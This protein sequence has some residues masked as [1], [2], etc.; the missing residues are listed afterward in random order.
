MP[1][2]PVYFDVSFDSKPFIKRVDQGTIRLL[3]FCK[4]SYAALAA[5]LASRPNPRDL[6][7]ANCYDLRRVPHTIQ[8]RFSF[9]SCMFF[10]E[11]E[12]P[13][14]STSTPPAMTQIGV[15]VRNGCFSGLKYSE[16][17]FMNFGMHSPIPQ[18]SVNPY[19]LSVLEFLCNISYRAGHGIS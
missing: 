18:A 7:S 17:D 5:S 3:P 12:R 8:P 15:S 1:L 9:I 10:T 11:P 6:P 4:D 13:L 16:S 19:M 2:S 14:W